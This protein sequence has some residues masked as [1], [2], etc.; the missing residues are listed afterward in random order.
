[1]TPIDLQLCP[2]KSALLLDH[3]N[4]LEVLVRVVGPPAPETAPVRKTLNLSLVIDKSSSM[5]GAP[6]DEAKRCAAAMIDR[7][8]PGDYVSVVAY[9]EGVEVVWP[10]QPVGGTQALKQAVSQIFAGGWTALHDGWAVGAEQAAAHVAKAGLSRVLLLSD[11]CANRGL[12]DVEQIA[13]RCA[14]SRR[15]AWRPRL[16]GW[17]CT[18]TKP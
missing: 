5:A 6:L 14:S 11:G 17:A 16:M 8:L 7:L 10:A 13:S 2:R 1:M 15:R 12:T 18:S 3:D 9:N 4:L